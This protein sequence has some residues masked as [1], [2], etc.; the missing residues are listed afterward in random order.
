MAKKVEAE[1]AVNEAVYSYDELVNGYKRFNVAKECVMAALREYKK[2][3]QS[4]DVAQGIITKFM[5][6]KVI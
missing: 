6:K 4:L 5:N 3:S 1:N 2:V